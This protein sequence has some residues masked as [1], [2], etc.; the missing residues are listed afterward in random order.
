MA[1]AQSKQGDMQILYCGSLIDSGDRNRSVERREG[2]R[3]EKP[4]SR[5][6]RWTRTQSHVGPRMSS[7]L[8]PVRWTAASGE[9]IDERTSC[10]SHNR[11][12]GLLNRIL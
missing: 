6:C 4:P 5:G 10:C 11:R 2:L 9:Q 8:E 7:E 3:I 12:I 1:A